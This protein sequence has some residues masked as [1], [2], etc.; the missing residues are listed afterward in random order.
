M[1]VNVGKAVAYLDIDTSRFKSGLKSASTDLRTFGDSTK[2]SEARLSGLSNTMKSVGGG[3]TKYVTVPLTGVGAASLKTAA[4][5]EKQMARVKSISGA[6]GKDF[7]ALEAKAKEMGATTIFTSKDAADA[8]E[9]MGMAG[10][11]ADQMI[12][13]L[14]GIMDL[15]AASGEDLGFV[16]DIVTDALT[17][18]GLTAKDTSRFVDVLA[19]ASTN[20]NTN[21]AMMG[22]TFK[23]AA[24]VAGALGFSVEDTA[25]AIGLMANSGIKASQAG[26]S[27]RALFT[28]LAKP[29]G[30]SKKAVEKL[31]LSLTDSEGN[32]KSFK[33]IMDELRSK[34]GE[35]KMPQQE[36]KQKLDEL[37]TA[38][39]N[40]T[41]TEDEYNKS[42]EE[43]AKN[44][45][46]AAD[47][48]KAKYAAMLAGR[49]GMSGLLAILNTTTEDYDKL[50]SAIYGSEGA[51]KEM[52][53]TQRDTLWGAMELLK[54]A[55]NAVAM[56]IGEQ[57]IPHVRATAEWLTKLVD[58]FNNLD[59]KTKAQIVN[60]GLFVAKIG[61]ALLIG[62]KVIDLIAKLATS[63]STV[64]K[65]VD[66]F[67]GGIDKL[68]PT[69][70]K[71]GGAVKS[72]GGVLVGFIVAHPVVA[73]VGAIIAILVTLYAKCEW[74]R[75][76]VNKIAG[77]L[78]DLPGNIVDFFKDLPDKIGGIFEKVRDKI[79]G[80]IS[81]TRDKIKRLGDDATL[82]YSKGVNDN[83]LKV[84][85]GIHKAHDEIKSK[86]EE[87][88]DKF[89]GNLKM[90]FN[91]L[92]NAAVPGLD[93]EGAR[94]WG[95]DAGHLLDGGGGA[96]VLH[97][98]AVQHAG[99]G[100]ARPD[101]G[102][103]ALHHF[104]GL[105]HFL[106][107]GFA[108]ISHDPFLLCPLLSYQF[109]LRVPHGGYSPGPSAQTG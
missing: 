77:F 94:V 39:E 62:S 16:S 78:K 79:G 72:F 87:A 43:L 30:E 36:V 96:V 91:S 14:P 42:V 22:E 47:A 89:G 31:G 38:F 65:G 21:V 101:A 67:L 84:T 7:K 105:A 74:F 40:G 12:A 85:H 107:V 23:Y 28:N 66:L 50:T 100:P 109:S 17:G 81:D 29:V 19:A 86:L 63:F 27:L 2:G 76:G 80:A 6:T 32:M 82:S 51:S 13:G 26:T 33:E 88:G 53:E 18:F 54:S 60:I 57:L 11:K 20:S 24:S 10:W 108:E 99:V 93:L 97:L 98:D 102:E 49:T 70:A 92:E 95:G 37:N 58:K 52:A 5:F 35:L 59:E 48:E 46:G 34:F 9:Y 69:L 68:V 83:V 106:V 56:T 75:D 55:I 73:A 61:P 25:I 103:V 8:M 64:K 3:M 45:L 1:S 104:D 15:A 44:A 41:I 4:E 71:V 90:G